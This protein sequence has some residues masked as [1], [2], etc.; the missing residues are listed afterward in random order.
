MIFIKINYNIICTR[1]D[2]ADFFFFFNLVNFWELKK[3]NSSDIVWIS[4]F[5]LRPFHHRRVPYTMD[6]FLIKIRVPLTW[7]FVTVYFVQERVNISPI[8]TRKSLWTSSQRFPYLFF[9]IQQFIKSTNKYRATN[10]IEHCKCLLDKRDVLNSVNTRTQWNR[11]ILFESVFHW[12]H[13]FFF[14]F[15]SYT[16]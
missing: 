11:R 7:G 6:N 2:R 1:N 9:E 15:L 13:H 8:F 4:R 10:E 14:F 16:R 12:S 3:Q 5:L